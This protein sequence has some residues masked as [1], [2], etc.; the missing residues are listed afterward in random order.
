MARTP[1]QRRYCSYLALKIHFDAHWTSRSCDILFIQYKLDFLSIWKTNKI[2]FTLNK[3]VYD[4][5][6][7]TCFIK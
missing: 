2:L 6:P 1:V 7:T 5:V 3:V 4:I